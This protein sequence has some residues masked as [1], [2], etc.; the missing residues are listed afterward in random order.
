MGFKRFDVLKVFYVIYLVIFT[1]L[2]IGFYVWSF[3]DMGFS[4]GHFFRIFAT[5][6]FFDVGVLSFFSLP[7]V[8]FLIALPSKYIGSR[9]DKIFTTLF[10]GVTSLLL[11]FSTFAEVIFWEEFQ[12]RFNFIAV[13]YLI[14]TNE[15]VSNI[16]QSYP[17]PYLFAF[18][19]FLVFIV[20]VLAGRLNAFKN[21]YQGNHHFKQRFAIGSVFIAIP[22]L[23]DS[24]ID[25]EDAEFSANRYENELSKA[26]IYSFFSAFRNSELKYTDFYRCQNI[27]SSFSTV[28][29]EIQQEN[30]N[31]I[32][33][34]K[35]SLLRLVKNEGNEQRPNVILIVVE[36]LSGSFLERFGNKDHITPT[37][38]SLVK[39]SVFFDSLYATGTRTERGME[40][41]MLSVPPSPGRSIIK[42]NNNDSL[43]T[44]GTV[45]K[46]NGYKTI[47]FYGGDGY[48]DNMNKFFAGNG[49]DIVDRGI[50]LFVED[51]FSVKRTHIEDSEVEFENAWGICDEDI[52]KKVLSVADEN[53][54]NKVPFF[55]FIM[56]TSNHRPYTYPSGR[57]DIPSG[58]GR[59]GAV[60]YADYAI[61][62]FIEKA[63]EKPWFRNTV[64]VIIADHCASSAGKWDLDV[65][66]HHIPALIYNLPDKNPQIMTKLC[67]QI[68]VFPTLF[69]YLNWTYKSKLYGMD[70]EK[71]TPDEERAFISNY[72]KV[73][74]IKQGSLTILGDQKKVQFFDWD[75]KTNALTQENENKTWLDET[76][77]Y[78]QTA[79][80]LYRNQLLKAGNDLA[81]RSALMP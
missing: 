43:F 55:N 14:Y 66:K 70:V 45:F 49:F 59:K 47:F 46:E 16:N 6:F 64:F 12:S 73:G 27:D 37:L 29:K 34:D 60:K 74:L 31:Y 9:L 41:L 25:N 3:E 7:Y 22:F 52:Y 23:F 77:S 13:D 10:F 54:G 50:H 36:S 24:Y 51:H 65:D 80:Y 53:Y 69:G 78:Y 62:Q 8:L 15:V 63:K 56:T 26:G 40:A 42:R 75:R 20:F 76:I 11:M 48:F 58:S 4:A 79:D 30:T 44:A 71:M 32:S 1:L 68:D 17:I 5:G 72:R 2:R 81:Y 67:S 28:K 21:T 35:Y 19:F 18:I 57:I 39:E 38:D 33:S 61:K